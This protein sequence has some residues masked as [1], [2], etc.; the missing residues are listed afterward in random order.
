MTASNEP[1]QH[2]LKSVGEVCVAHETC[3]R[4]DAEVGADSS[5]VKGARS[6][7]MKDEEGESALWGRLAS[8]WIRV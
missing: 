3:C 4:R 5:D 2:Q 7:M 6:T 8:L 1:R